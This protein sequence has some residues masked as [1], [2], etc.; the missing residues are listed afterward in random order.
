M[1]STLN[2]IDRV[3]STYDSDNSTA[4]FDNLKIKTKADIVSADV[5]DLKITSSLVVKDGGKT[6][7]LPTA[8]SLPETAA[9]TNDFYYLAYN[10]TNGEYGGDFLVKSFSN[11]GLKMNQ[12]SSVIQKPPSAESSG[13]LG[14]YQPVNDGMVVFNP[15]AEYD[16]FENRTPIMSNELKMSDNILVSSN[17][18]G[19]GTGVYR[20]TL[21]NLVASVQILASEITTIGSL[22]SNTKTTAAHDSIDF[23]VDEMDEYGYNPTMKF[24]VDGLS[25]QAGDLSL[26]KKALGGYHALS[27]GAPFKVGADTTRN[28]YSGQIMALDETFDGDGEKIG[29]SGFLFETADYDQAMTDGN[30]KTLSLEFETSESIVLKENS[31][32]VGQNI[33]LQGT[34]FFATNT[35]FMLDEA[36]L[37]IQ[38]SSLTIPSGLSIVLEQPL[39]KSSSVRFGSLFSEGTIQSNTELIIGE[40]NNLQVS[41]N[42]DRIS[43]VS[44]NTFSFA[45]N[46]EITGSELRVPSKTYTGE[47]EVTNDTK[48]QT[49]T[50]DSITTNTLNASGA[51]QSDTLQVSGVSTLN[52]DLT[53]NADL[54]LPLERS[55]TLSYSGQDATVL[56]R[57]LSLPGGYIAVAQEITCGGLLTVDDNAEITG[58]LQVDGEIK[59]GTA[60]TLQES[61]GTVIAT[62]VMAGNA[63]IE[64]TGDVTFGAALTMVNG[65]LTMDTGNIYLND[66][67]TV[68]SSSL[69]LKENISEYNSGLSAIMNMKPVT[70]NRKTKPGTQE[71]GFIAEEMEKVLPTVVSS[72]NN[73]KS[74][75]YTEI[76]PVLVS[77]LQ[78]QQ[79]KINELESKLSK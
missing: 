6:Y 52:D 12:L 14:I 10:P 58:N 18:A 36:T 40:Q 51:L 26:P 29:E 31:V 27:Y 3:V 13:W 64:S 42:L 78:E 46:T 44:P 66:G 45:S 67:S 48:T 77:A 39:E 60:I 50:S 68:T 8:L 54:I 43:F 65:D 56:N 22:T 23:M 30:V 53:I 55:I 2:Y 71:F 74:I 47:L 19:S 62:K 37:D 4:G 57:N 38:D 5:Q 17:K 63:G 61:T 1:S 59:S 75:K 73:V 76:I 32:Q 34:E 49:L 7:R 20:L 28:Y 72:P 35:V 11:E 33:V 79:Q 9:D 41:V 69:K 70:Y 21:G 16:A 25:L 15:Q 24:N